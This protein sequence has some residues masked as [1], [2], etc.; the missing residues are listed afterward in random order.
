MANEIVLET[1]CLFI[2]R[3]L[4]ARGRCLWHSISGFF[5]LYCLYCYIG[6]KYFI[7]KAISQLSLHTLCAFLYPSTFSV[8][9]FVY[10]SQELKAFI[11]FG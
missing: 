7:L 1:I 5:L 8:C 11:K 4:C 3:T 9:G 6:N 10:L 2:Y